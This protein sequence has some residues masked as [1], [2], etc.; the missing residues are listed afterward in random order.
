MFSSPALPKSIQFSC[1]F[2]F[3]C[4]WLLQ[5]S[6]DSLMPFLF[7][8]DARSLFVPSI[9]CLSALSHLASIKWHLKL[10][11]TGIHTHTHSP[12]KLNWIEY[13]IDWPWVLDERKRDTETWENAVLV[14]VLKSIFV[15]RKIVMECIKCINSQLF[16]TLLWWWF[17]VV[18]GRQWIRA[19]FYR[20]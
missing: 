6:L 9:G 8:L 2:G 7:R 4:R 20:L 5:C 17:C 14:Y 12:N 19:H 11:N 10:P 18:M 15:R 1:L 3:D 13:I 16:H